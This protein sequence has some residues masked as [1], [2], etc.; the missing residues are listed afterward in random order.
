[1]S[2]LQCPEHHRHGLTLTC[3]GAHGCRCIECRTGHADYLRAIR[4]LNGTT[5]QI[6]STGTRR[7]LRALATLG[8]SVLAIEALTGISSISLHRHRSGDS[9]RVREDVARTIA[10]LYRDICCTPAPVN[11]QTR[12]MIARARENGWLGPMEWDNIDTDILPERK[13]A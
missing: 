2:D 10:H 12:A 11:H 1:M 7:R 9:K 6:P 4:K 13:R 5:V 8:Y 3:Y